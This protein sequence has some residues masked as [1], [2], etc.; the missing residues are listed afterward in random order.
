MKL[1]TLKKELVLERVR[2]VT[3]SHMEGKQFLLAAFDQRGEKQ[4]DGRTHLCDPRRARLARS[5]SGVPKATGTGHE[6]IESNISHE[7]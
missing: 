1:G 7:S 2:G 5:R 3:S 4:I 6:T